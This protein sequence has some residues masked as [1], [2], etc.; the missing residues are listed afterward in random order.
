MAAAR[1]ARL[2]RVA[3]WLHLNSMRFEKVQFRLL[4]EQTLANVWRKAAYRWLLEQH[5]MLGLGESADA[6]DE[7]K[8]KREAAEQVQ[9]GWREL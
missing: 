7:G 2:R 1:V 8:R 4:C 3:L 5:E 6:S 9:R